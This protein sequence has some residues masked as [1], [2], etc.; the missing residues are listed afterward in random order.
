MEELMKIVSQERSTGMGAERYTAILTPIGWLKVSELE[1]A[2]LENRVRGVRIYTVLVPRST[3]YA[4]FYR[5]N[6]GNEEVTIFADGKFTF[7]SFA[8][9]ALWA[10]QRNN[11]YS[12]SEVCP[13]CHRALE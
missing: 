8:L 7:R 10:R 6:R 4:N 12:H 5:S 13:Y 11:E 1:N 9:A 2:V 3:V